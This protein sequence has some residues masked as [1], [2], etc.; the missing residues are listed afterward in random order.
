MAATKSRPPPGRASRR[1]I[2]WL[3]G[4]RPAI[5]TS[6]APTTTCRARHRREPPRAVALASGLCGEVRGVCEGWLAS[7]SSR[8]RPGEG[9]D[10]YRAIYPWRSVTDDLRK[11]LWV[12]AFAGTTETSRLHDHISVLDMH[13]KGLGDVGALDGFFG[14]LLAAFDRDRKGPHLD[15]LGIEPG[16]AV[17]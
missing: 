16:L 1:W 9:R 14:K 7:S 17:A 15:A 10:P 6:F 3:R 8:Q 12:P 2:S 4:S 5:S 11:W 13:R